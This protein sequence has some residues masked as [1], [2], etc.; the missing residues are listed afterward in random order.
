VSGAGWTP[1]LH[2]GKLRKNPSSA[3]RYKKMHRS[4]QNMQNGMREKGI[5][6]QRRLQ[7]NRA[8]RTLG[9]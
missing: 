6:T 9:D 1:F 4:A 2:D 3:Q 8:R 7:S 5:Q